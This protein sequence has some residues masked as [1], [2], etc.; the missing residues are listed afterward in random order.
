MARPR[1]RKRTDSASR[2][3]SDG[4]QGKK[5]KTHSSEPKLS[6]VTGIQHAMLEQ[7][8]PQVRNLRD[9]VLSKLPPSSRLRRKKVALVGKVGESPN[10]TLSE[11]EQSV[12]A[13]L[14]STLIGISEKPSCGSTDD[15]WE[16]WTAFSQKGD[17]SYVTL[18]DGNAGSKFSQSEIVDFAIWL[19]FSKTKASGTW[20][21]HLLCDGFRRNR[22]SGP[23]RQACNDERNIPGLFALHPNPHVDTL[24]RVPW[25]QLLL[26]LGQSGERIMMDLLLDCA[27]FVPVNAGTNNY[28]QISG[29]P[30]SETELL[31]PGKTQGSTSESFV[32]SPSDIVFVRNRMLYARAALN[33]RGLVHFGLRH[34]HV[35]NRSPYRQSDEDEACST[36]DENITINRNQLNTMRVMMYMFPRQFGLHN[37]FTSR[38]DFKETSQRLKD[39]TLREDEI[40]AKFGQPHEPGF[41]IHLPK[42]LR[43]KAAHESAAHR[44][45]YDQSTDIEAPRK[46]PSALSRD[47]DQ[48]ITDLATPPAKVSAFCQAALSRILPNEFFGVGSTGQQNKELVLKKVHQFVLLRR[49]EGMALHEVMQGMKIADIDWLAPPWLMPNKTSQTDMQKRVELFYEFLYFIF[50]SL[51]IPLIRSNFYVTESN[52]QKYRLFFFRHD[53]WRYVAEPSM[54]SLKLKMFEEVNMDDARRILDSRALGFTQVRLL[55]K[56]TTMRPITNLRRRTF[57]R[58]NKKES[59]VAINKLLA[60]AQAVLQLEAKLYFAKLDVQSAFDTIPQAAIVSLLDSIPQARQYRISKYLQVAPNLWSRPKSEPGSKLKLT[61]RWA[62]AAT[63]RHDASTLTSLLES[64]RAANR[65]NTVFVDSFSKRDYEASE[66]LQLVASHIQQNLVKIGKKFYRQKEGIPQGS[67][68]SSTLCNYFYADLE[69]HVLPFLDSEDCLLLR[70]IDDFLLITTDKRKAV[71]FVDTMHRGVPEYGVVVNPRKTLVN[72]ELT[73]NQQPVP[74]LGPGQNFPYCGTKIDCET[75]GITRARDQEKGSARI[76]DSLTVEFSRTPGQSFQRKVLNAFKIQSHLMFF[77]TTLNSATTML[78]NAY[79]AFV[80]TATKTWAYTRCLPQQ[81]QPP[82]SL[83][84]RIISKLAGVAY[85]LLVSKTRKLRYPGYSCD[86]RKC[87]VSWVLSRKQSRYGEV[88]GWLRGEIRKLGLLKDIRYGRVRHLDFIRP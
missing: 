34:I 47:S 53:V 27:I 5:L 6:A 49:F 75:L 77:D 9:Y 87:E 82:A 21:K 62:L 65:R 80:E 66:L 78:R 19:L 63:R 15:R 69:A 70:L 43:G 1:K 46:S 13:L 86:I 2:L 11:V 54:S 73:L 28:C 18:S 57:P 10:S 36:A 41:R 51:L 67:V 38:V 14:D 88:I 44:V 26:L 64:G 24:K 56:G 12:G 72:F 76:Y 8:Y 22:G 79:D 35:L 50:D 40:T 39:Y 30:L 60:P 58:G 52:H 17:E 84:T 7:F 4:L 25:P 59:G 42:R 37:V 48:P 20:P 3:S 23:P 55:P 68:L 81:K 32:K 83:V 33:A 31:N 74:S 29:K 71:R 45:S 85:L 16:Q 61:K